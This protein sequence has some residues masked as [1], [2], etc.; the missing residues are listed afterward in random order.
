[1]TLDQSG[2]IEEPLDAVAASFLLV[3]FV[4]DGQ[5]KRDHSEKGKR[6]TVARRLGSP[7]PG[8]GDPDRSP[9]AGRIAEAL[10]FAV[11]FCPHRRL[12]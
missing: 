5:D 9:P 2:S 7:V 10:F 8:F 6:E 11:T 3:M 4:P 1:V 12:S